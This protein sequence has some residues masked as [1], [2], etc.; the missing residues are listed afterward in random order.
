MVLTEEDVDVY[1]IIANYWAAV[2]VTLN[3]DVKDSSTMI[4]LM[5]DRT[6]PDL[7]PGG[8]MFSSPAGG[9]MYVSTNRHNTAMINDPTIEAM[10]AK[11]ASLSLGT[12]ESKEA[13]KEYASYAMDNV[14]YLPVAAARGYTFWWPWVKQ[15][16][17][18]LGHCFNEVVAH[19]KNLWI[20]QDMK[21]EMGY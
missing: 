12:E 17:G 20:D 18:E 11:V 16:A 13:V 10:W 19:T 6:Y 15:Y 1:S 2:D 8:G 5:N 9:F 4:A 3:L 21:A 7:A 14:W